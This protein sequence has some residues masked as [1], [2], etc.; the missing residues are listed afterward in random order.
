MT[1]PPLAQ[2]WRDQHTQRAQTAYAAYL[3]LQERIERYE[4]LAQEKYPKNDRQVARWLANDDSDDA[5][6][7]RTLCSLRSVQQTI[8]AMETAMA[9]LYR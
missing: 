2:S 9:G 3:K 5:W 4:A 8:I 6:R 1:S 7:Y